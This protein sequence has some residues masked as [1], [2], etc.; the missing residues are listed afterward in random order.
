LVNK[1]LE[2]VN[3]NIDLKK[4][5]KPLFE[6]PP[7]PG[8]EESISSQEQDGEQPAADASDKTSADHD[9]EAGEDSDSKRGGA[10]TKVEEEPAA[11]E[12][13]AGTTASGEKP[14]GDSDVKK[15]NKSRSG[16][17]RRASRG[18][19]AAR[20][21]NLTVGSKAVPCKEGT[22]QAAFVDIL[23]RKEGVTM[24][25]LRKAF[26]S[27]ANDTTIRSYIFWNVHEI[28]GYGVTTEMKKTKNGD[29]PVFHL[30]LPRGLNKPLPHTAEQKKTATKKKAA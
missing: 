9:H 20:G 23:A 14:E 2:K 29:V 4:A 13:P 21:M 8:Q 1:A 3:L 27:F 18:P 22:K 15:R 12:E 24:E 7:L 10:A 30:L 16:A 26:P 5:G 11:E 6:L 28:K 17:A 25:Q 19:R